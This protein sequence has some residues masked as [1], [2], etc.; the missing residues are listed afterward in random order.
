MIVSN[1]KIKLRIGKFLQIIGGTVLSFFVLISSLVIFTDNKLMILNLI[2]SST[3]EIQQT[4]FGDENYSVSSFAELFRFTKG[5][6]KGLASTDNFYQLDIKIPYENIAVLEATKYTRNTKKNYVDVIMDVSNQTE[7]KSLKGK[8]RYKGDRE[9]HVDNFKKSSFRMNL[10]GND[11]LFGLEEFSIQSPVIRNYSWELLIA[12]TF[13]NEELLTLKTEIANLSVNGDARGLFFIEEVPST[14]TLE[15]QKRK[16]GP[17]FGLDENFGIGIDSNLDVYDPREWEDNPIYQNSMNLLYKAFID[18]EQKQIINLSNFEIDS[19]AKY[20]ALIDVFGS[21]H[22][23][24]PKSVRFYFNPVIGKFEPMLFD[25]HLGGEDLSDFVLLDLLTRGKTAKCD[26]I[27]PF[28]SFHKSFLNNNEFL[29]LYLSYLEKY[30][31]TQFI[32]NI[33]QTYR[34]NYESIDNELYSRFSLSDGISNRALSL[35]LFKLEHVQKRRELIQNKLRLFSTRS[36]EFID[37]EGIET[38]SKNNNYL[39][40]KNIAVTELKDVVISGTDLNF[41]N[42]T[43]LLLTG[44]NSILGTSSDRP[45]LIQ[46]PVMF[47]QIGGEINIKNVH[48][49]NSKNHLIANRNWSAAVNIIESDANIDNLTLSGSISEDAINIVSSDFYI[50]EITINDSLSDAIDL[51][52]ASGIINNI[53]CNRIGND[54][55]DVSET[56][57]IVNNLNA[58]Y[59]N[60]KVVSVGENSEINI[61]KLSMNDSSIGVVSKDGS[62]AN[63]GQVYFKNTKLPFATFVKKSEYLEPKLEVKEI[64]SYKNTDLFSLSSSNSIVDFPEEVNVSRMTSQEIEDQMYGATYGVATKK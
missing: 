63:I 36:F 49:I 21:H 42:P 19:W 52:F 31:S 20:F 37:N 64:L 43:I 12:E 46:G 50:S 55:F 10:K 15:R 57:A 41:D 3:T 9:I 25:A 38:K 18:M 13:R 16:A 62:S 4:I 44:K 35:Y 59:V 27:C 51:D 6:V 26:W 53:K 7:I 48:F 60:D 56:K 5:V 24:L 39:N 47:V 45:L 23:V 54:C 1:K 11:R 58:S 33:K 14:R 29:N 28:E 40:T 61:K 34:N 30:S 2:R 8:I 32:D 17:I 22:G